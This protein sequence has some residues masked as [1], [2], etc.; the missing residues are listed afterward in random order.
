MINNNALIYARVSTTKQ[1]QDWDSLMQQELSCRGYCKNNNMPVLTVFYEAFS[2]KSSNRPE[3]LKA[4]E[5]AK[6]N[7]V[8]YFVVFDI[9]RFSREGYDVYM[10]LKKELLKHGIEL[11]DSKNV[12]GDST[13]VYENDVIDMRQYEWNIENR[14]EMAEMVYSAQWKI[15]WSKILQ[16]TI[17]REIE[18][19]Q[20]GFKVRESNFGFKNKKVRDTVLWWKKATIQVEDDIEWPWVREMFV[21]RASWKYSDED[22]V[23]SLNMKGF[24]TRR[25]KVLTVKKMQ[26]LITYTVYAGIITGKWTG[27]KP[28]ATPYDWLVSIDIWNKANKW[29]KRIIVVDEE[30]KEY[31]IEHKKGKEVQNNAPIIKTRKKHNPDFCFWK[32]LQCPICGK[33]L[34]WSRSIGRNKKPHY[35]YFCKG[36]WKKNN[37]HPAYSIKRDEVHEKIY[38]IFENIEITERLLLVYEEVC[39]NVFKDNENSLILENE[40]ISKQI[41]GLKKKRENIQNSIDKLIDYPE[42]L[43]VKY[44]EFLEVKRN[45]ENLESITIQRKDNITLEEFLYASKPVFKHLKSLIKQRNTPEMIEIAFQICFGG[46]IS[47]EEII[48]QTTWISEFSSILK[49]KN[50]QEFEDFLRN[51]KWQVH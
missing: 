10:S 42:L 21:K 22:I 44:K 33:S 20:L 31:I 9:D 40:G 47:Y 30:K 25:W 34:I 23:E 48:S 41:K 1:A 11:R 43:E 38:E 13:A 19:E 28:I 39:K 46:K 27:D 4:I 32:V 7:N 35:Y 16:R 8:K 12:I 2:G 15:E 24:K 26:L 36:K 49:Q 5:Y 29:K 14:S 6:N 3:F 18:L 45:I 50:P 37:S 51:L 17:T